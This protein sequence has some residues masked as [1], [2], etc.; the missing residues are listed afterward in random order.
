MRT[1]R[2]KRGRPSPSACIGR[3]TI[4]GSDFSC[5]TLEEAKK[6]VERGKDLAIPEGVYKLRYHSPSRFERRLRQMMED[7]DA[8]MISV[9]NDDVPKD[10]YILIH[11]GNSAKDTEG[12]ILLGTNKI[13][14]GRIG[15]SIKACK[16]FYKIMSDENLDDWELIIE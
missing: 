1:I 8:K 2:I 4:E 5:Y 6:G 3:L 15:E 12:C 11:W 13:G 9:Y 14:S 7:D 10:R 16:E